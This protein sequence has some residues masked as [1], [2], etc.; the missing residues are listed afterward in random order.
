M[1][2]IKALIEKHTTPNQRSAFNG[3]LCE[4][5]AR[6]AIVDLN[7]VERNRVKKAETSKEKIVP[8][9]ELDL[10]NVEVACKNLPKLPDDDRSLI[11]NPPCDDLGG[12]CCEPG[13]PPL[14]KHLPSSGSPAT[15][16]SKR[17]DGFPSLLSRRGDDF[18]FESTMKSPSLTATWPVRSFAKR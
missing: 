15:K 11:F 13:N 5:L 3:G 10:A 4:H 16:L 7:K 17:D 2:H 6:Q 8:S 12:H 1:S 14:S 18:R 9:I